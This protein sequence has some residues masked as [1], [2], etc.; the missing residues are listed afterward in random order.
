MPRAIP[1]CFQDHPYN[2]ES[3]GCSYC[4]NGY[5]EG[6]EEC[7]KNDMH[8]DNSTCKCVTGY[9]LENVSGM[10]ICVQN[11][12][13]NNSGVIVGVVVGVICF[14]MICGG[15]VVFIIFFINK[16]KSE[17]DD[18]SVNMNDHGLFVE[19][20]QG[21][22]GKLEI[23]QSLYEA[24]TTIV[25]KGI[26]NNEIDVVVKIMKMWGTKLDSSQSRE[27]EL[28][29]K[30]H[31]DYIVE[32]YGTSVIE[33]R[34]GI[35]M[36]FIPLGSLEG[37][38]SK[39]V[40]SSELKIRYVREIC[41]GMKYLHSM[42]IIH[43]DLKLTNVLVVSDDSNSTQAICKISDFGT[44]R[45]VDM[46][47]TL[48]MSQSMTMTSNIGT[49][50]YMAP[51][52]LSGVGHYSQ[53]ADVY[54]YGIL[55]VSLWNQ[56]PPYYEIHNREAGDLLSDITTRG[57]RPRIQSECPQSYFNL[58]SACLVEDPHSRPSF[59]EIFKNVFDS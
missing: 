29:R 51:E 27:M 8:C 54:S 56:K 49:P 59:D 20:E 47:S 2:N 30:L 19:T 23:K 52:I 50:L 28:M 31:S 35:V 41:Y 15:V 16:K 11:K 57:L 4:G 18:E 39:K 32:Y 24:P 22:G 6:K 44:S 25:Y 48:S 5:V 1:I 21:K 17:G 38:M 26:M 42:N 3:E 33:G 45:E 53:K 34:L 7:D 46:K 37:L 43:R 40:L 55:M 13:S 9:S 12:N 58:V 14:M 10:M 36:E